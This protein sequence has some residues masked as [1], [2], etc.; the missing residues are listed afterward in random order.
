M[1][2]LRQLKTRLDNM[3]SRVVVHAVRSA[4]GAQMLQA[5][6]LAGEVREGL[7]HF[8]EYGFASVPLPGAEAVVVWNGGH[9]DHGL[10]VVCGDRRSRPTNLGPGETALYTLDGTVVVLRTGGRIEVTASAKVTIAS[11]DVEISGNLTVSGQV[12][13]A[14]GTMQEMRTI[15]DAHTHGGVESGSGSSGP[16]SPPMT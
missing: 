4:G 3:V 1:S 15:Y 12:A 6:A 9:R 13:D 10:V 8:Q 2:I 11:P 14:G 7:E 5:V 16:P